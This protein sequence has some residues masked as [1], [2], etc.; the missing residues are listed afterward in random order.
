MSS[1]G[2]PPSGFVIGSFPYCALTTVCRTGCRGLSNN[3]GGSCQRQD[4]RV[5]Q[6]TAVVLDR[7]LYYTLLS[8]PG[9]RWRKPTPKPG[10]TTSA[11]LEG[12]GSAPLQRLQ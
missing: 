5:D 10:R 12:D 4:R 2:S 9:L 8:L 1:K 3:T 6:P 11:P 7:F